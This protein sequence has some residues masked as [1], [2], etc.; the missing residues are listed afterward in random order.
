M[1]E[2]IEETWLLMIGDDENALDERGE[3]DD[4]SDVIINLAII[5]LTFVCNGFEMRAIRI[6]REPFSGSRM[7]G[8]LPVN[9]SDYVIDFQYCSHKKLQFYDRNISVRSTLQKERTKKLFNFGHANETGAK[10]CEEP[11]PPRDK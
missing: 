7:R 11:F 6:W 8:I 4:G 9:P 10:L 2:C 5:E 1:L 3:F